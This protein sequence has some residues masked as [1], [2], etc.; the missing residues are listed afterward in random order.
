MDDIRMF[1]DER[2]GAWELVVNGEWYFE[3]T[4]EQVERMADTFWFSDDDEY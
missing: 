1:Y 2:R 4:Y 3:G